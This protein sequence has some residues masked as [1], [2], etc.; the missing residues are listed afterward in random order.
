MYIVLTHIIIGITSIHPIIRLT[1]N[2]SL[3]THSSLHVS[4]SPCIAGVKR[5]LATIAW[6]V[7]E[8]DKPIFICSWQ[9]LKERLPVL[10]L[11]ILKVLACRA[12]SGVSVNYCLVFR[13]PS[14]LNL[15]QGTLDIG[16]GVVKAGRSSLSVIL[17]L[18]SLA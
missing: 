14:V 4:G 13:Q 18:W 6:H 8:L 1:N 11:G 17:R 16:I 5:I 7:I 3:P 15:L 2:S 9:E 12:F 10:I